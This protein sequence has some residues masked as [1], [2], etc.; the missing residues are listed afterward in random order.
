M[1]QNFVNYKLNYERDPN[2]KYVFYP[3]TCAW[4]GAL[5]VARLTTNNVL[6]GALIQKFEPLLGAEA[7][8]V[9]ASAHVDDRVFGAVPLELFVQTRADIYLR[10]GKGLADQQWAKTTSDGITVEARYWIDD[11]YMI[12]AVQT[13][14]Y[15]ATGD[16]IY[17]DR[18][19][20]AM[21]AY[22]GKLQQPNGLFFHA[23]DAPFY[24]SRGNGWMAAGMTELLRALPV[25]H[26]H[27]PTVLAAYRKMMATLLEYQGS[28]GLWRQLIDRTE[29]WPETSGS[30]MFTFAMVTGVKNGWLDKVTFG[31]AARKGWLGLIN[32]LDDMANIRDVCEGTNKGH[33][34]KYYLERKRKIGDLHGQAPILWCASALLRPNE[35]AR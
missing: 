31:P 9:P 16:R 35:F 19:A 1:A 20:R 29:A 10:L 33:T 22:L 34:Q 3:E 18:A 14:A 23:P 30:G 8:R 32:C 12:T 5:T 11:M 28:D 6:R 26:P 21:V 24:W 13:Q 25:D 15:R 27:R 4:Y 17:L 2:W 7:R